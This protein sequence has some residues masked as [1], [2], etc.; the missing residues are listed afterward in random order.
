MTI[1]SDEHSDAK[2]V[3]DN[4]AIAR[5]VSSEEPFWSRLFRQL[6]ADLREDAAR[7]VWARVVSFS[8]DDAAY[9]PSVDALRAA[10]ELSLRVPSGW[11]DSTPTRRRGEACGSFVNTS[12]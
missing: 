9:M 7:Y 5:A 11:T 10:K 4:L 3:R 2:S 1:C 12:G 8:G 6:V